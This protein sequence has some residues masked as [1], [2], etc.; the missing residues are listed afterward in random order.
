MTHQNS[1]SIMMLRV[2]EVMRVTGLP[3]ST[4]YRLISV[5]HFP[6]PIKISARAVAWRSDAV[7][8]WIHDR[9]VASADA[10]WEGAR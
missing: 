2:R 8:K 9:S 6:R 10:A 1:I 3:R 4:I 5:G 7:N